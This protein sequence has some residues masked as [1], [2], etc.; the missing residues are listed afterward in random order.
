MSSFGRYFRGL[1]AYDLLGNLVP[2][3][4]V[5]AGIIGFL[6][7]PPVPSTIGEHA[8]ALIA[9]FAI[10]GLV[11]E[12]ASIATGKRVTFER[13]IKNTEYPKSTLKDT[14]NDSP[15]TDEDV[16]PR[17]LWRGAF[18]EPVVWI[19]DEIP[20]RGDTL[21]DAVLTGKIRQ[22]L[23][24][25]HEIPTD[26]DDFQVLYHLM[27][28]KIESAGTSARAVRMQ[29]LRNFYRGMW[30]ASWWL[31]VFLLVAA[32][33]DLT[34]TW[35]SE[36]AL[37]DSIP[38]TYRAPTYRELWQPMWQLVP[39]AGVFVFLFRNRYESHEEDVIEYL[40]TDYATAI[41]LGGTTISFDDEARLEL[42]H[43]VPLRDENEDATPNET[44]TE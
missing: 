2:G 28:S 18:V 32:L 3:I 35:T 40:F 22:H 21:D 11:Q 13:T 38:F 4:V 20:P 26:F 27:Y 42:S 23:L 36:W 25:T 6:R 24:D 19:W 34:A 12:H 30:L 44:R 31:F 7:P 37:T 8:L 15:G 29:A 43:D 17:P 16:D 33:A 9:A 1:T 14:G 10:G 39:V 41:E 5:V